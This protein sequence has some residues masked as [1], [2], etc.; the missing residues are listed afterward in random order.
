MELKTWL[1]REVETHETCE[2]NECG[3][4][5]YG[6]GTYELCVGG[7]FLSSGLDIEEFA[8]LRDLVIY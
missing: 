5:D 2:N 3:C 4:I 8:E 6:D 7:E 1:E